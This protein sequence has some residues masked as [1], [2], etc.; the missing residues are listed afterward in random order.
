MDRIREILQ[1]EN[2][3]RIVTGGLV[4]IVLLLVFGAAVILTPPKAEVVEKAVLQTV[5][6]EKEVPVEVVKEVEK[7]V[8]QTVVVEKEVPVAP[9]PMQVPTPT[10]TNS[11]TPPPKCPLKGKLKD[12][13]HVVCYACYMCELSEKNR[14]CPG[15]KSGR[16]CEIRL[17]PPQTDGYYLMIEKEFYENLLWWENLTEAPMVPD[18]KITP[19]PAETLPQFP[20]SGVILCNDSWL[21][22]D[23]KTREFVAFGST[24]DPGGWIYLNLE[25]VVL[26]PKNDVPLE[27][28]IEASEAAGFGLNTWQHTP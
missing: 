2:G 19:V 1:G 21:C 6:V 15:E 26:G 8:V 16:V 5:V 12:G 3:Q 23:G 25:I 18:N 11:P 28:I 9:S 17:D 13:R 4:I 7:P 27:V 20:F 14:W 22:E 24:Q 10:T